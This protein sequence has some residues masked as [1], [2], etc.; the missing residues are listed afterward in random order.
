[1]L[2]HAVFFKLK[3]KSRGTLEKVKNELLAL[4][5]QIPFIRSIEVGIDI[6]QTERSFDV[7][8]Y[9]KF[10]SLEDMQAYQVHPEHVKFVEYI[11]TVKDIIYSVDFES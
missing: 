11:E 10:D 7:V 5:E 1:M 4:K 6:L 8:L 2:T 3:D 9:S